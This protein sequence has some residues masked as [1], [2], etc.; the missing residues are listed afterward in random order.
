MIGPANL[1][2][3]T[4]DALGIPTATYL[5][6]MPSR[7]YPKLEWVTAGETKRV[8]PGVGLRVRSLG[9]M[10]K[11]KVQWKY[12]KPAAGQADYEDLLA[13]LDLRPIRV[14]DGTR[15]ITVEHAEGPG[16]VCQIIG[17]IPQD[18]AVVFHGR[19]AQTSRV[20]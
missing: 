5:L 4:L 18:V 8:I 13:L 7:G 2:I 1:Q 11:L 12:Y 16:D 10:P 14:G 3:Q 19:D 9:W 20:I 15:W 17:T 6:P